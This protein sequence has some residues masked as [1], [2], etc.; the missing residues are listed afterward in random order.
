MVLVVFNSGCFEEEG[1]EKK[2]RVVKI[3]S[4]TQNPKNPKAG[5]EITVT[6]I[7]E[8]SSGCSFSHHS[9][10][11]YRGGGGWTMTRINDSK[12]ETKLRQPFSNGTEV[13]YVV[14]AKG[15]NRSL[16]ASDV[17]ITQIGE[18]ERSNITTLAITNVHQ[19]PQSPTTNDPIVT[20][21]ADI[22]S[23]ITL[24]YVEFGYWIFY[25]GA[26]SGT[27][28]MDYVSGNTYEYEISL[29]SEYKNTLIYY[30]IAAQDESGNTAVSP[31]YSIIISS[32]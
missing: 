7:V 1:S 21:T 5:D 3:I 8:N 10:F 14:T 30:N 19:S 27:G 6:A 15:Y 16:I 12:Y 4:V 29:S 26:G 23:N 20:V 2:E 31:A 11:A 28:M 25:P 32:Y 13:W 22:T 24:S 18:V 9:Y 17:Y